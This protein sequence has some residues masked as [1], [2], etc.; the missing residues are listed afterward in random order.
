[1]LTFEKPPNPDMGDSTDQDEKKNNI[2]NKYYQLANVDKKLD[3]LV[4]L[5]GIE[6][7]QKWERFDLQDNSTI[8]ELDWADTLERM[9]GKREITSRAVGYVERHNIL[10]QKLENIRDERAEELINLIEQYPSA[11]NEKPIKKLWLI[12]PEQ[13]EQLP[14]ETELTDI[15][16]RKKRKGVDEI[17]QDE[18][19][20]YLAYGFLE[21]ERPGNIDF[22]EKAVFEIR[23]ELKPR[24]DS[25]I[26]N[27]ETSNTIVKNLENSDN[28]SVTPEELPEKEE[29]EINISKMNKAKILAALYNNSKPLGMGALHFDPQPMTEQ[30]AQELLDSGQTHFDYLKGRVMKIDLS[31]DKLSTWG[32]NRD[33][34]ENAAETVLAK[35]KEE[36][37][38]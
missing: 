25:L 7:M 14:D 33:I 35:L 17:S 2:L 28:D 6:E 34:G 15:F 13:F 4:N 10:A 23:D 8:G 27:N 38:E 3:F 11:E 22:N 1:M 30:E 20:G 29:G 32:Y 26:D 31:G 21:E 18:R 19:V 37:E 24:D 36:G 12:T 5:F 9:S 16:G